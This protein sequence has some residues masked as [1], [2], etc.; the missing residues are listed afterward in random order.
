MSYY[1]DIF[2][3]EDVCAPTVEHVKNQFTLTE[4]KRANN[5]NFFTIK[6]LLKKKWKDHYLHTVSVSY[7]KTLPQAGGRIIHAVT[8]DSLPGSVGSLMENRYFKVKVT[9]GGELENGTLF[10]LSPSEYEN[11][12]YC[13]V[14]QYT[15]DA[16]LQKQHDI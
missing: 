10:Y 12:Q 11:H 14:D 15:V 1:S 13:E 7:Y 8:G 4:M 9:S 2:S 6:K 16:W 3:P 5:N